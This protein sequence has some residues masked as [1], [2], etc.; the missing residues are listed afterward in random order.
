MV[1]IYIK[2][3]DENEGF[4]SVDKVERK[5]ELVPKSSKTQDNGL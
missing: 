3:L 5:P 2:D 4:I 1:S